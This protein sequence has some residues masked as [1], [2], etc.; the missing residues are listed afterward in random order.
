MLKFWTAQYRYPGPNRL[1]ITVKGND[2]FG[3]LFAPTWD[4]LNAYKN[5]PNKTQAEQIYIRQYHQIILNNFYYLEKLL[6][7]N[8]LVLICFCAYGKFCHRH[9]LTHY[10]IHLGAQYMGEITDFS[11]WEQKITNFDGEYRWLSNFYPSPFYYQGILYP[12]NEH[13][14]QAWKF[15]SSEHARIAALPTPGQ[16]KREG[17]KAQLCW[18]WDS[19]KNEVMLTGLKEKF[20]IPE[21]R[22]KLINT[23]T[24]QLIEGNTWHDNYWGN[25]TC[26]KCCHI[27]GKNTLGSLLM[28]L[29]HQIQ[30]G[31]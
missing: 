11:P 20:K 9:L 21:L 17:R 25:C 22:E 10:L 1:D 23:G 12:T 18:N 3:K 7:Q 6:S 31:G 14:F 15:P 26:P 8:E 19:I 29:R 13:F 24:I 30:Q 4:M 2:P 16:S 5:N 27:T 28:Q